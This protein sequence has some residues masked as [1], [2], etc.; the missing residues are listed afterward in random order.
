[1]TWK[2]DYLLLWSTAFLHLCVAMTF[3]AFPIQ[4]VRWGFSTMDVAWLAFSM[5]CALVLVRPVVKWV[6]D[7][8][9]PKSTLMLASA[10]LAL[11]SLA[12]YL[13]DDRFWLLVPAKML[14]GVSLSFL[15][16]AYIVYAS[17]AL[18]LP[19]LQRGLSWLGLTTILPQLVIV[20][21]AE[22]LL[23]SEHVGLFFFSLGFLAIVALL[24]ASLLTFRDVPPEESRSS[25]DNML[26]N[27]LFRQILTITFA[28][29]LVNCIV[30]TFV[31]LLAASRGSYASA[32]FIPYSLGNL[33]TR[34]ILA[35]RISLFLPMSVVL[36]S[37]CGI[38]VA[39]F[40]ISLAKTTA[41]LA[42]FSGLYGLFQGPLDPSMMALTARLFP[43]KRNAAFTGYM[44]SQD[45][46]WALGPLF[47]GSIGGHSLA[48]IFFLSGGLAVTSTVACWKWFR[49]QAAPTSSDSPPSSEEKRPDIL[50]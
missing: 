24:C 12:M 26:Q 14:H 38:S 44:T 37:L 49:P 16:V 30:Q 27:S 17:H 15:L 7:H 3:F 50:S 5:D 31:A 8:M 46:A 11:A 39:V 45:T 42:L 6:L 13:A 10:L 33:L 22:K 36:T 32:F 21:F 28:Q 35:R 25:S 34:G 19:L 2:R 18:P 23:L 1:M 41:V 48:S 9:G 40:G 43:K 20:P 4:L 29:N 47:G